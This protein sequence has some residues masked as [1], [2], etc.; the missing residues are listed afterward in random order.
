MEQ[1]EGDKAKGDTRREN[2]NPELSP[3]IEENREYKPKTSA[4]PHNEG[5]QPKN[6]LHRTWL[7]ITTHQIDRIVELVFAFAVM[8]FAGAQWITGCQNNAST[9]QQT[10]QL[11]L[12]AWINVI[13]AQQNVAA[14]Q[15]NAT[16]AE[17]FSQSAASINEGVSGAVGKL[18]FQAEKMDA[19]RLSSEADSRKALQATIDNFHQ[20]QRAWVGIEII[21]QSIDPKESFGANSIQFAHASVNLRNTGKTPALNVEYNWEVDT[22]PGEYKFEDDIPDYDTM[23]ASEK[24]AKS[25][26]LNSVLDQVLNS[27]LAQDPTHA[28]QIRAEDRADRARREAMDRDWDSGISKAERQFVIPPNGTG[29]TDI[30]EGSR[31]DKK[32][33]H[34]VGRI[35]YND[36]FDPTKQH[37][38]KFCIVRFSDGPFQL[39]PRG[40]DMN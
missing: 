24:A 20:E 10:D 19:S 4:N 32:F 26:A 5:N 8:F 21:L 38:T 13:S 34:I 9:A 3:K 22:R 17:R 28:D 30:M 1:P 6:Y 14:S 27:K 40:Q 15:R 11:I 16:A 29:I 37:I 25:A 12:A 39:C 31:P 33:H 18:Q 23:K 36:V 35:R 2:A 7:K